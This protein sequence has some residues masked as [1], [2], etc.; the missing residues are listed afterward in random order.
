MCAGKAAD[1][2][3]RQY[4]GKLYRSPKEKAVSEFRAEPIAACE[5][6]VIKGARQEE[7]SM[8]V[9]FGAAV[10]SAELR[11]GDKAYVYGSS[12]ILREKPSVKANKVAV[13]TDRAPVDVV[14][15]SKEMDAVPG[16]HKAYWFEVK[17]DGKKGWIY[18]QFIHPDPN[19][20]QLFIGGDYACDRGT[21]PGGVPGVLLQPSA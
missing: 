6:A 9:Q 15:R 21:D 8:S 14:G 3:Q 5:K 19:S 12:V 1:S 2:Q 11:A 20:P 18:G 13:L 16:L 7:A 17:I 4:T 10:Y